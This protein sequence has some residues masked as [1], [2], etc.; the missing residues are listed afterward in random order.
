M[1]APTTM[2]CVVL[3]G[4]AM[5]PLSQTGGVGEPTPSPMRPNQV[6]IHRSTL[7]RPTLTRLAAA[8]AL[9]ALSLAATGCSASPG[10][11]A[12]ESSKSASVAGSAP[13]RDAATGL[14]HSTYDAQGTQDLAS[15]P[16]QR[17]VIA[18]GTLTIAVD[19]VATAQQDAEN[20]ATGVSGLVASEE[21]T[22]DDHGRL[23]S[24]QLVLRVPARAFDTSMDALAKLGQLQSRT[25]T[26][27]DVT[28]QVIDNTARVRSQRASVETIRRLFS[29][30]T[31]IGE[32]VSIESQLAKRQA[33]LDSLEQQ[34]KW[35]ADQT[36]LSTITLT[37]RHTD[38]VTT[39]ATRHTGFLGGLQ[40]GW[41]G[42]TGAATAMLAV[43]GA[44]L[45]YAVVL[46]V[47]GTPIWLVWRRRR[48][49]P[50]RQADPV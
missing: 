16:I 23:E 8:A 43:V 25:Q 46:G 40:A 39:P 32:V 9:T 15:Q 19:S 31:T 18:Q 17:A 44:V 49:R 33:D 24:A 45:P 34:Q 6:S 50:T 22:S 11:S 38:K 37:V 4:S 7:S 27:E 13:A 36:S 3:P 47:V 48:V 14:A 12:D 21:S 5:A 30:A 29:K 42:L 20:L 28:T 2:T 26:A 1:P 41:H 10:T 35:L